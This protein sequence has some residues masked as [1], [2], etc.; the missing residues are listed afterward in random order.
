MCV[1]FLQTDDSKLPSF[2]VISVS[3]NGSE[4]IDFSTVKAI[5]ECCSFKRFKNSEQSCSSS[6]IA[7]TSSTY[8]KYKAEED[9]NLFFKRTDSKCARKKL[10]N[11]GPEGDPIATR[12]TCLYNLSLY[13]NI[14]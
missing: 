8:L 1:G 14:P 13:M 11:V 3:K 12:S 4:L 5:L 9:F 6:K 2:I 7:N 10:E